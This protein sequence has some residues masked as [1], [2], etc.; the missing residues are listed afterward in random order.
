ML[1]KKGKEYVKN[2]FITKGYLTKKSHKY[3]IF[4]YEKNKKI[5]GMSALNRNYIGK[6]YVTPSMH[7][8]GIGREM[9]L[10]LEELAMKNGYKETH[11]HAYQNSRKFYSKL[12]Y[13]F[14]KM[15]IYHEL[16]GKKVPTYEMKKRLKR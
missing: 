6:V 7:G 4:V 14:T 1:N 12:G 11:L 3:Y 2:L 13:K 10:F 5:F 9:M 8:K 16:D 15:F